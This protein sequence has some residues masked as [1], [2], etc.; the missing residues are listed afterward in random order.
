MKIYK[1]NESDEYLQ[2]FVLFVHK[3]DKKIIQ[4]NFE[5]SH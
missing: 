2:K 4:I 1:S 5:Y 3:Y